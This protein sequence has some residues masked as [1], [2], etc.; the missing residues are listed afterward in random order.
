MF[1]TAA[2]AE[3]GIVVAVGIATTIETA[4]AVETI[5]TMGT[6]AVVK[7]VAIAVIAPKIFRKK[8]IIAAEAEIA[9]VMAKVL[10]KG[11]AASFDKRK[12]YIWIIGN[13]AAFA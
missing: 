11:N 7:T 4:V 6:A 1:G 12:K 5:A 10:K 8:A 13:I 9:I 3:E 2:M